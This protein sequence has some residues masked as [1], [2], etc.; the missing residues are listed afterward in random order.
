MDGNS[1]SILKIDKRLAFLLAMAAVILFS[2]LG[3]APLFDPDEPVY[4]ETAREMLAA[5]DWLSPRIYGDYWYDKPPAYYWAVMVCFRMFGQSDWAARLPSA[6]AGTVLVWF[7]YRFLAGRIGRPAAFNAAAMLLS[8]AMFCYLGKAA[9]TDMWLTTAMSM[10]IFWLWAGRYWL[11][12]LASGVAILVKGPIGWFLPV[13]IFGLYLL[14]AERSRL[15]RL[16]LAGTVRFTAVAVL[17]AAPWYILM[18]ISHGWSFVD[19]FIGFHNIVR[20]TTPEHPERAY[21]YFYLPWLLLGFSPWTVVI[22]TGAA[23]FG[24]YW[25]I[26]R[27]GSQTGRICLLSA[28]WAAVVLVFFSVCKTKLISY[29]FPLFVPLAAIGGVHS[30]HFWN[31]DPG[32][33]L[34]AVDGTGI[35]LVCGAVGY[36]LL[37]A[38]NYYPQIRTGALLAAGLFGLT[39]VTAAFAVWFRPRLTVPLT[40]AGIALVSLPLFGAVAPRLAEDFSCRPAAAWLADNVRGD[41][42]VLV[43]KFLRPGLAWY[44]RIYGQPLST[45]RQLAGYLTQKYREIP[46]GQRQFIVW[47]RE[48]LDGSVRLPDGW[49]PAYAD[50]Y[51]V[52]VS[53]EGQ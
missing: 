44:S 36:A 52:I 15:S 49:Q 38:V 25:R 48:L 6:V 46:T 4:A 45:R 7:V 37:T 16:T 5:G 23:K 14:L 19:T 39:G 51:A 28:V 12:G 31:D 35:L 21:W 9:V 17:V 26:G 53:W 24:R 33:R 1:A 22:F 11:A 47:R 41:D 8:S 50:R 3:A 13:A 42:R 34:R 43:D 27:A 10:A 30:R 29:I 18:F 20:F 2:S 40:V 32:S